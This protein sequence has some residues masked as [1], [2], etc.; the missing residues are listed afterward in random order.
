[1]EEAYESSRKG[2]RS[3]TTEHPTH[4]ARRGGASI[5]PPKKGTQYCTYGE[6]ERAAEM[7]IPTWCA[8][9]EGS[10]KAPR[11]FRRATEVAV[12]TWV[13]Q[14][15]SVIHLGVQ[16]HG[17]VPEELH[18]EDDQ[19][20]VPAGGDGVRAPPVRAGRVGEL[21]VGRGTVV[22]GT[23]HVGQEDH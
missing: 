20:D 23:T 2:R 19:G 16:C 13:R 14:V 4:A 21:G 1:M 22:G 11:R 6:S 3:L 7:A 10:E 15:D 17:Q 18:P 5:S 12:P 9:G 8:Y